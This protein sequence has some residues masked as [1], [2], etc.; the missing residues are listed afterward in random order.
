VN[1]KKGK[2]LKKKE[3][4]IEKTG[5]EA[6]KK[7]KKRKKRLTLPWEVSWAL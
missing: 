2:K 5:K 7:G 3:S 6:K 1:E 4:I